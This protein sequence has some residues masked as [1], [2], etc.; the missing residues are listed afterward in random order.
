M[1]LLVLKRTRPEYAMRHAGNEA[2]ITWGGGSTP[3]ELER[4]HEAPT[5]D[6]RYLRRVAYLAAGEGL[7]CTRSYRSC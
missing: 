2:W 5:P 1:I 6:G 4:P 3:E 7:R